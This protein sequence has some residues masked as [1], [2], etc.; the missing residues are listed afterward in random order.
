MKYIV[1]TIVF[2]LLLVGVA[3]PA[4]ASLPYGGTKVIVQ[5]SGSVFVGS[6]GAVSKS[7]STVKHCGWVT[8]S[9]YL[10]KSQTWRLQYNVNLLGGGIG[11]LAASCGL[12]SIMTGPAVPFV[13]TG[14]A[15]FVAIYGGFLLNA[16]SRAAASNGCLRIRWPVYAFYNDHSSYC[17]AT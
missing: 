4:Q 9:V 7:I 16:L 11:G 8:C 13:V 3:T 1:S 2:A 10:S 14:C 6:G 12:L 15:A 5:D 17:R